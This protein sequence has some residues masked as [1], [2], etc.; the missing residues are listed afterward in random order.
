MKTIQ[1]TILIFSIS[2]LISCQF[3]GGR[4]V[5]YET[6]GFE[7][8]SKVVYETEYAQ[9]SFGKEDVLNV[10][11]IRL[12]EMISKVEC[13][14]LIELV[15]ESHGELIIPDTFATIERSDGRYRD[16]EHK[17]AFANDC[18]E[19]VMIELIQKEKVKAFNKLTNKEEIFLKIHYART[20][21]HSSTDIYLP[22]DS[23]IIFVMN[24]IK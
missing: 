17:Y 24:W 3:F 12:E 6:K 2:F 23:L 7:D 20:S 22:N 1:I 4:K 8:E 11:K 5:K 13:E 16:S 15:N 9:I 14:H 18:F 10:A 21:L 19:R